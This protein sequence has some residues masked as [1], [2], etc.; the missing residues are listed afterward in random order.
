LIGRKLTYQGN[1]ERGPAFHWRPFRE[2]AT[3]LT[4][5][6]LFPETTQI[7]APREYIGRRDRVRPATCGLVDDPL[8]VQ[9]FV[10]Q[11]GEERIET[12]GC[13]EPVS[14]DAVDVR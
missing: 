13:R 1:A 14:S 7:P 11:Q 12:D 10:V 8:E 9:R 6:W 4:E 3:R 2:E 5:K